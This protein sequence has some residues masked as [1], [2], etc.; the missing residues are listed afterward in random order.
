VP[1]KPAPSTFCSGSRLVD[2]HRPAVEFAAIQPGDG[3]I[4]FRGIGHFHKCKSPRTPRIAV[5]YKI[6]SLDLA[7][8]FKQSAY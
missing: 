3:T 8:A 1:A 4:R 2:I 7:V 6:H 5:R